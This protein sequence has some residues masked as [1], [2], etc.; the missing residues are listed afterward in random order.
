M[1]SVTSEI[2]LVLFEI[3]L[4]LYI[5]TDLESFWVFILYFSIKLLLI[6]VSIAP[7]FT[8]ICT[9]NSFNMLVISKAINGYKEVLQ[10]LRALMVRC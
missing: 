5:S 8:S 9:D 3:L 10:I 1:A 4:I 7:E 6:K 2:C